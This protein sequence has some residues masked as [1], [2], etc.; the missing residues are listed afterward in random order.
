VSHT[1]PHMVFVGY[2]QYLVLD[3]LY[4]LKNISLAR[5]KRNA[6]MSTQ[7]SDEKASASL[8]QFTWNAQMVTTEEERKVYKELLDKKQCQ[9]G[10]NVFLQFVRDGELEMVAPMSS[11]TLAATLPPPFFV[12]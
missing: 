1:L 9:G 3:V 2:L 4:I 11:V 8:S 5:S 12:S 10:K 7:Q 6:P